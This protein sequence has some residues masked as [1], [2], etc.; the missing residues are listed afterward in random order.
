MR[1]HH[2]EINKHPCEAQ[3]DWKCPFMPTLFSWLFWLVK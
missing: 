3:L 1:S 2:Q